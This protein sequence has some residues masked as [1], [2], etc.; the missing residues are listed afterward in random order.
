MYFVKEEREN[1]IKKDEAPVSM[2]IPALILGS[3]CVIVGLLWLAGAAT[4]LPP[5]VKQAVN[6]LLE[7]GVGAA[8]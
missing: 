7:T 5:I 1:K 2:V 4:P 3:L 6:T 8:P